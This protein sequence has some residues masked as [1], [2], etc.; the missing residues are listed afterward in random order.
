MA[1]YLTFEDIHMTDTY[2]TKLIETFRSLSC[3]CL[4]NEFRQ[5]DNHIVWREILNQQKGRIEK[6][7]RCADHHCVRRDFEGHK[8]GY[9]DH[10]FH[11]SFNNA[12]AF[13]F[14]NRTRYDG[15][16]FVLCRPYD[17]NCVYTCIDLDWKK[18]GQPTLFQIA[19]INACI[20]RTYIEWSPSGYGVH[21][22]CRG[23]GVNRKRAEIEIYTHSRF[24]T[25]TFDPLKES[26]VPL[27]NWE[28]LLPTLP[29]EAIAI[30]AEKTQSVSCSK[31]TGVVG[32]DVLYEWVK[33]PPDPLTPEDTKLC[34]KIAGS[35][36]GS[37]FNWFWSDQWQTHYVSNGKLD[38]SGA[39]LALFNILAYHTG[40]DINSINQFIRIFHASELGKR[41]KA[42]DVRYLRRTIN[43]AFDRSLPH[44]PLK[45]IDGISKGG[46]A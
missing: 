18:T 24:L 44:I 17:Q 30:V 7:P 21:I 25:L 10:L 45:F 3:N 13:L 26:N 2:I 8:I 15:W 23:F 37:K 27:A 32:D 11:R 14:N 46:G 16:G 33:Y 6:Q 29:H 4:A 41:G 12:L 39:D 36:N 38:Q 19:V 9:L 31:S 28:T 42:Y 20:G 1:E 5:R 34:Y 40:F 22:W 35:G 43:R